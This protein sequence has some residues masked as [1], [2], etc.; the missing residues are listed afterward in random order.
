[1]AILED[2]S[3]QNRSSSINRRKFVTRIGASMAGLTIP[4]VGSATAQNKNNKV[5]AEDVGINTTVL[6][7]LKAGKH[8][9]AEKLLTKHNIDYDSSFG[10]TPSDG[11]HE[12]GNNSNQ[13]S[14]QDQW[15]RA[16][17]WFYH[18]TWHNSGRTYQSYTQWD[19]NSPDPIDTAGPQDGIGITVNP[20]LWEIINYSWKSDNRSSLHKRGIKGVIF[21]FNDPNDTGAGSSL[22]TGWGTV[23]IQKIERGNHNI[24]GTYAHTWNVGGV[25]GW[26]SFG[27]NIGPISVS[28]NGAVDHWKKRKDNNI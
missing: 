25:P 21:D 7:L 22:T 16:M 17:S 27:L 13:I 23:K 5:G 14:T 8:Q 20:D 1:M 10:M 9:K 24:Y 28:G 3:D 2:M 18:T 4:L 19:L 15:S 12:S 26:A 11:T 6:E